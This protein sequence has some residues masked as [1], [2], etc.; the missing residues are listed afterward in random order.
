MARVT[1]TPKREERVVVQARSRLVEHDVHRPVP[2]V[3]A[4]AHEPEQAE[5]TKAERARDRT[6]VRVGRRRDHRD[7]C[8]TAQQ[9]ATVV[10]EARLAGDARP[11]PGQES[12]RG[13]PDGLERDPAGARRARAPRPSRRP[14]AR[15]PPGSTR[16][17]YRCR[18]RRGTRSRGR[19]AIAISAL[20]ATA[21][22]AAA[23]STAEAV[24][25]FHHASR[26]RRTPAARS[27][28]TAPRSRATRCAA[29]ATATGTAT[30][31]P[32]A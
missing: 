29:A 11:R 18:S 4:V 24:R 21:P 28:R 25:R 8:Q 14:R 2:Q 12:D 23:T 13:Q 7:P 17:G 32:D 27:G 3:H 5:R 9:E 26:P 10:Q 20:D 1:A 6:A 30:S 31:S 15:P 19:R 22:I 16:P